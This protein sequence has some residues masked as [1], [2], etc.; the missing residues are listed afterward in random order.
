MVYDTKIAVVIR[1]D[2]QSWQK[3]NVAC[4][5]CGG[6]AGTYPEIVGEPYRD[7]GGQA[8]APLIRQPVLIYGA[9]PE[10]LKRTRERA[11][12]RGLNVPIYT[13]ELFQTG[14]DADNR[15]AVAAVAGDALNLVGIALYAERKIV[16]KV[17]GGL[18]FLS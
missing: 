5:L 1:A 7:A 10:E 4:F 14:N 6:L 16:D 3:V 17:T 18:K 11:L 13:E 9:G 12:S 15:A 2:L 8:Y